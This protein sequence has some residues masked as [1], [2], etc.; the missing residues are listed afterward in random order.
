MTSCSASVAVGTC[1]LAFPTV[2]ARTITATYVG[3]A[4]FAGS[5]SAGE[6]HLVS[7]AATVTSI[8]GHS[9]DPSTTSTAVAVTWTVLPVAPGAGAPTGLVTVT[10][11]VDSCNA[12]VAAGGCSLTLTTGGARSLVA[13]YAGDTEFT[14]SSSTGTAHQVN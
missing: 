8:T 7:Q 9:P 2:G 6:P 10:D 14:G 11:G 3:D 4:D 13:T 12:A 1:S 5:A